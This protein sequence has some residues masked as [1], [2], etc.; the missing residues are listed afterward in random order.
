MTEA[1]LDG[2]NG[3][4]R[5]LLM[6]GAVG[7]LDKGACFWGNAV[8]SVSGLRATYSD[9]NDGLTTLEVVRWE[10][11]D[12]DDM[13]LTRAS[14]QKEGLVSTFGGVVTGSSASRM[15]PPESRARMK[16]LSLDFGSIKRPSQRTRRHLPIPVK[17]THWCGRTEIEG[18]RTSLSA[19]SS[20]C[21]RGHRPIVQLAKYS[22]DLMFGGKPPSSTG[23][24]LTSLRQLLYPLLYPS[25][26][27][28]RRHDLYPL[29]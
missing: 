3:S 25:M 24:W 18:R 5:G 21:G 16:Y 14:D 19:S 22:P 4:K 10:E 23:I 6:V 20:Q 12:V 17:V 29:S 8:I 7:T 28:Y 9:G 1:E 13:A 2:V 15:R 11:E 27:L 26:P